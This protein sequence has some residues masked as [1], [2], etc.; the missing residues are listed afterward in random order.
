MIDA[1]I[2]AGRQAGRFDSKPT[3]ENYP[4]VT[5]TIIIIIKS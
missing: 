2:S 3:F 5:R 1:G 4:V